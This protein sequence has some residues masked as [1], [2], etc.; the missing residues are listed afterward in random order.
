MKAFWQEFCLHIWAERAALVALVSVIGLW[1]LLAELV[2]P[3]QIRD[4]IV[5][6]CFGW[7]VL[8]KVCVPWM[9]RKLS[10]LFS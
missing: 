2:L 6:F 1:V 8:G 4:H 5:Y 3:T 7:F 10:K 9:E